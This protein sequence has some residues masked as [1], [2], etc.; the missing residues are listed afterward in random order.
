MMLLYALVTGLA[1][2]WLLIVVLGLLGLLGVRRG[3][4]L[5]A[6]LTGIIIALP[7]LPRL[8]FYL[9]DREGFVTKYGTAAVSEVGIGATF[10]TLGVVA[11][12][13]T[14]LVLSRSW[15]WLAPALLTLL[16]LAF[17]AW[18]ACCFSIRF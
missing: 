2:L 6:G 9:Y 15:G 1:I 16:P 10:V 8:T 17:L 18:M 14:P 13:S 3:A 5:A 7:F 11:F 12:I 4:A